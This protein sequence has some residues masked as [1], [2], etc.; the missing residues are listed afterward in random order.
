MVKKYSKFVSEGVESPS[1]LKLNYYS[2]DW[3]DNLLHMPT[4]IHMDKKVEDR[5]VPVDVS[6]TDFTVCRNDVNYRIR[7]GNPDEA[8]CEFRDFGPRGSKA[9]LIDTK[10]ALKNGNFA[11]SWGSFLQCLSDGA[12]FCIITARGHEP[13]SIRESVEYIIDTILAK[14]P[15]KN[16]GRTLADEMY[17]NILKYMYYFKELNNSP[18]ELTGPPSKNI[19]IKKYLDECDF[20]GVT[21]RFFAQEFG[22]AGQSEN[23]V[24]LNPEK[25][26]ELALQAFIDKCNGFGRR[27]NDYFR[28]NLIDTRV[29]EVSIGFSDDDPKNVGHVKKYFAEAPLEFDDYNL[30]LNVYDTSDRSIKGGIQSKFRKTESNQSVTDIVP[31][32]TMSLQRMPAGLAQEDIIKFTNY[33]KNLIG[34][35]GKPALDKISKKRKEEKVSES[36][37]HPGFKKISKKIAK[38]Q[39]ISIQKAAAMLASATR[40]ASPKAKKK[41]PKLKKVKG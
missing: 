22:R 1:Y 17:Q 35:I 39:K 3:D 32:S 5:W 18:D 41:N 33:N 20:Y 25:A 30:K 16:P 19:V 21:S 40:K 7:N 14:I 6:T 23:F 27:L 13:Q 37:K 29:K 34:K 12:I 15:S 11:P 26:K 36:K 9:F 10:D 4:V 31:N 38:S 24:S 2:F 28:K 8:F